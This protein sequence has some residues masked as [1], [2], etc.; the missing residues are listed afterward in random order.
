MCCLSCTGAYCYLSIHYWERIEQWPTKGNYFFL[1]MALVG[2]MSRGRRKKHI[3]RPYCV[4]AEMNN[5]FPVSFHFIFLFGKN[6]K[7]MKVQKKKLRE[8]EDE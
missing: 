4:C 7:V 5:D 8:A 1:L 2:N 6:G 3:S